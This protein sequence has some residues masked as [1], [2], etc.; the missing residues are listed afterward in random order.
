MNEAIKKAMLSV[1]DARSALLNA[2]EETPELR[3]KLDTA[4]KELR[5]AIEKDIEQ[6]A[7]VDPKER[8]LI[9]KV[10]LRSYM[11]AAMT[12]KKVTGAEAEL[13][14]ERGLDDQ[15]QVPWDALLP[16]EERQDVATAV[17]AGAIGHP[18]EPVLARIF[19]RSRLSFLGARMPSVASG[20]P[21]YPVMTGGTTASA[22]AAGDDVDAAAATFTGETVG[23]T[24]LSARYKW[25]LE[26]SVRFPVEEALRSDLRMVMSDVLDEQVFN[27]TGAN[28]QMN[29]LFRNHADGPL[30]VSAAEAARTT[31]D[32][33]LT[34]VYN[35]VDGAAAAM[36]SE[37]RTLIGVS[38]HTDWATIR[39]ANGAP[40]MQT[41]SSLGAPLAVSAH[42]P[43]AAAN[44][45]QAIQTRRPGDLVIPVWQGVTMIRDPYSDAAS[46]E[47]TLTAHF[48]ANLK[49]LRSGN[50]RKV[51]F[52]SA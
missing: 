52:K 24:R 27:G 44:V 26:D 6:G 3:A 8:S 39:E 1:S 17:A 21:I 23:P 18:Q 12:G 9:E 43:A 16:L 25:R 10:E 4:E 48:L 22:H 5:T 35:Y 19:K 42:V 31:Y 47:V 7:K 28:A 38:T 11:Q 29:G 15:N 51:A 49:L 40:I 34:K 14:Q 20:E 13:N 33:I 45:Q 46:A 32:Q 36:V 41:L 37:V 2:K 30:G 50:W